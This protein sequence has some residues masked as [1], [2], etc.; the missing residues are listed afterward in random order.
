MFVFYTS[1][2][3]VAP[4]VHADVVQN[5]DMLVIQNNGIVCVLGPCQAYM[6]SSLKLEAH[7]WI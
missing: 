5:Y 6:D 7:M 1:G 3:L 2:F 4:I